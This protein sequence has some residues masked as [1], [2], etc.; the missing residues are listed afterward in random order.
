[1]DRTYIIYDLQVWMLN[2][3]NTKDPNSLAS[4]M[5]V[6][7][8]EVTKYLCQQVLAHSVLSR[9]I[10]GNCGQLWAIVLGSVLQQSFI[11]QVFRTAPGRRIQQSCRRPHP[12]ER[13]ADVR[14]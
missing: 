1:M 9:A 7:N 13:L 12:F 2:Y 11:E 10:V 4:E 14:L 3:V 8:Y 5:T 6:R